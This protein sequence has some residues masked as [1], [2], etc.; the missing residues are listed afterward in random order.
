MKPLCFHYNVSDC[1]SHTFSLLH[2]TPIDPFVVGRST[3]SQI[4]G[5]QRAV[6]VERVSHSGVSVR[7][8]AEVG[9][10]RVQNEGK[11]CD[12]GA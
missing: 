11:T 1:H 5:R 12:A 6:D 10:T 7:G 3:T 4:G 8:W 9:Y 2:P